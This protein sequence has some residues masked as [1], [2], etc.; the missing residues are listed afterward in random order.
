[1]SCNDVAS[2]LDTHRAARLA[3]AERTQVDAH[4]AACADCAAA[5]HAHTE[6]LA[7]RMPPLPAALLERA[8]LASRLP[9]SA[10]ARRARMPLIVGS[11][12]LAGAA[13]AAVTV[14]S[15]TRSPSEPTAMSAPAE[16]A[17]AQ[18]PAGGGVIEQVGAVRSN[19]VPDHP[20]SVELV[21]VALGV[22]PVVRK[23]PDYP[24]AGLKQRLE[25]HVQLQFDVTA[26]GSVEN[27]SVIE[28]S[29]AL[30]EEPAVRA[31]SEWRYLPRLAEGKRVRSDGVQTIIRFAMAKEDAAAPKPLS[32]EAAQAVMRQFAAFSTDLEV[33]IDRL[34]ADDFRGAELQLDE[35][36]ALYGADRADL[37]SF[38]GYLYTVQGNYDRAIDAYERSVAIYLASPSPTSAA[39]TP[40]A[41]LYYARHQYDVALRTLLRPLQV[42]NAAGRTLR[43]SPDGEALIERLRAL[44]VTEETL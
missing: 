23:N 16:Q 7:L 20:I 13:A 36:Q 27:V 39:S 8:L 30:F 10:P 18:Q 2:I 40:L 15:L 6:L 34:A 38:Y 11:A 29:D 37:W 12:V 1:M 32:D 41:N 26:T 24:P 42:A 4:L 28:S 43:L 3:P 44:G 21:E 33:A 5:W 19:E 14:V 35:M 25:G 22:Q 17:G 31:L 9:Q